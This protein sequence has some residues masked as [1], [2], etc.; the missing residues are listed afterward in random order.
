MDN[1]LVEVHGRCGRQFSELVSGI[2]SEQ[3]HAETP[4]SE[5]DVRTLVHHLLY[6]QR[7][8]GPLLEGQTTEQVGD[9]FEGD[10]MGP[11]A[12]SWAG[13]FASAVAQ[14]H[15]AV[16]APGA[17]QR[18]VHPSF[19]DSPGEEYVMQL[20]ADLAI[21]SWDLARATGQDESI[22]PDGVSLILPWAEANSALLAGSG[23][24]AEPV[25]L[26]PDASDDARL[27]AILGRRV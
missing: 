26:E 6:E 1:D 17:L 16:D 9:R 19:G 12:S 15:E 2:S 10:L 25:E 24:F 14:A 18:T 5:W 3:W 8:T 13:L 4:C 21:H 20:T 22:D 11:D 27:L 23:M 7:W